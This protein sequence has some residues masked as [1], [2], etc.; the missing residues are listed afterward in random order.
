[1]SY[2]LGVFIYIFCGI[3]WNHFYWQL[4]MKQALSEKKE[5]KKKCWTQKTAARGTEPKKKAQTLITMTSGT[6]PM[7]P[8]KLLNRIKDF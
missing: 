2:F 1:M 7:T 6:E 4:H 5:E 3:L 8:T